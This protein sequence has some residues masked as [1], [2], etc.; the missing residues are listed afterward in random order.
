MSAVEVATVRLLA[1][2]ERALAVVL[3]GAGDA[4][5]EVLVDGEPPATLR[6]RGATTRQ[7]AQKS[8]QLSRARPQAEGGGAPTGARELALNKHP[9]DLT[10]V[11]N[12]L[13]F[14]SFA[15]VPYLD[16]VSPRADF[17]RLEVN[18]ADLG[19]FTRVEDPDV[20]FLAA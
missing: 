18:G 15:A 6:L 16:R 3:A 9:F 12:K 17:V 19:L 7:T 10:R 13:A 8:F 2:D 1:R 20:T 11:R 14:D 5:V 4:P